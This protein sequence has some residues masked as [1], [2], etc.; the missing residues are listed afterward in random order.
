MQKSE[1]LI[2]LN[3]EL[4]LDEKQTDQAPQ[5][6]EEGKGFHPQGTQTI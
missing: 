1:R 6:E 5:E 4:D 3:K 2:Q